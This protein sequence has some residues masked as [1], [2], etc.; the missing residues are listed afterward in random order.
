MK[1]VLSLVVSFCIICMTFTFALGLTPVAGAS[2]LTDEE[3]IA[4]NYPLPKGY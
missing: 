3:I 2:T 1:K 4:K